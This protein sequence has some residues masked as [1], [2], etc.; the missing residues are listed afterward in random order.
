MVQNW[1][2]RLDGARCSFQGVH[3]GKWMLGRISSL[4]HLLPIRL[5]Q[6]LLHIPH[7]PLR[8]LV[9]LER[10]TPHHLASSK[11]RTT[12]LSEVFLL[13]I[14]EPFN[15]SSLTAICRLTIH[16]IRLI[17]P[18]RMASGILFDQNH[19]DK[20]RPSTCASYPVWGSIYH[21]ETCH[22][23]AMLHHRQDRGQTLSNRQQ[24]RAEVRRGR[25]YPTQSYQP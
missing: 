16:L 8:L 10:R 19:S 14:L 20:V 2:G 1:M 25:V 12:L 22:Y 9:R 18:S 13:S 17:T 11:S 6:V 15:R 5:F 23:H 21:S 3:S 7:G 24:P 4:S